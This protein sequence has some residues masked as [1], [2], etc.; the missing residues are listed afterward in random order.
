MLEAIKNRRSVRFFTEEAVTD[1]QVSEILLAGFCA[2]SAHNKAPWH[3]VLV[4]DQESKTKLAT[5]HRWSRV[6]ARSPVVIAVCVDKT[7]LDLFWVEDGSA[8]IENMM[9]QAADMGLGTCWIGVKGIPRDERNDAEAVVR[10]T[11][12]L[13]EH[14]GVV[15]LMLLGHAKRVPDYREPAIPADRVH[16]ESYGRHEVD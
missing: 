3:A 10:E 1:E 11:L 16:I 7:G 14:F 4:R 15:A 6:V 13:P 8:F 5:I 9:I 2:P 12:G